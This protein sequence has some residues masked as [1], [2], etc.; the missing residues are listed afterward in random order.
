MTD[1]QLQFLGRLA[2]WMIYQSE[3]K[4]LGDKQIGM[5]GQCLENTALEFQRKRSKTM[6]LPEEQAGAKKDDDDVPG[7]WVPME[8]LD[9]LINRWE[10]RVGSLQ[11]LGGC[12]QAVQGLEFCID[13]LKMVMADNEPS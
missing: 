11:T 13:H 6:N 8:D 2:W 9:F 12:K 3:H 10:H 4:A 5:L 1:E 7:S